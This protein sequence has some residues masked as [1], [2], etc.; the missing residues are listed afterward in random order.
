MFSKVVEKTE[1]TELWLDKMMTSETTALIGLLGSEKFA[2][3]S[4]LHHAVLHVIKTVSSHPKMAKFLLE[5][6][7]ENVTGFTAFEV[8]RLWDKGMQ[9]T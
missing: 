9:A 5:Q 8:R 7:L 3:P 2:S 6:E 4:P 1:H